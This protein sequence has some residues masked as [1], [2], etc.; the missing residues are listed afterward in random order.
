MVT[1]TNVQK[2]LFYPF[3]YSILKGFANGY[4]T[5]C[6]LVKKPFAIPDENNLFE[7]W[8]YM[9]V[10]YLRNTSVANLKLTL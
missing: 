2:G 4:I 7:R 10:V 6:K 1:S 5:L 3:S 8:F 9:G